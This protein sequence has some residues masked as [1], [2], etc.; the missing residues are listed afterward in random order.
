MF[1]TCSLKLKIFEKLLLRVRNRRSFGRSHFIDWKLEPTLDDS[2]EL[3]GMYEPQVAE[4]L[5]M[6]R[7]KV[8]A[9]VA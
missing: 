4:Q 5:L 1:N 6:M 8:I 3:G 9:E 2:I 7:R